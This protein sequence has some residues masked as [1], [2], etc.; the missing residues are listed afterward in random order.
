MFTRPP[1]TASPK[2]QAALISTASRR[3]VLGSAVNMTPADAAST[4]SWTTT[5]RL[6]LGR[7]DALT[8][9][10]GHRPRRPQ[11]GPAPAYGLQHRVGA[12]D[13]Q[14]GVLLAGEAGALEVLGGRR[15]ADRHGARPELRGRRRRCAAATSSGTRPAVNRSL[16]A[17]AADS[18][19]ADR[20]RRGR[21]QRDD[22][23]A[24]AG[25]CRRTSRYAAVVTTKPGGTGSPARPAHRGW[26]PCRRP[27][28]GRAGRRRPTRPPATDLTP[29]SACRSPRLP[30]RPNLRPGRASGD[31]AH[32]VSG[33]DQRYSS[34][35]FSRTDFGLAPLN[36]LTSSPP[37]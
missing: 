23:L 7:V 32:V 34:I 6:H 12:A 10:V 24:Q 36:A 17:S 3:P 13:V 18:Y 11:R 2:P 20:R 25:E 15:G 33:E 5:A 16:I 9:P 4:S 1:T 31:G 29:W 21:H 30:R 22:P 19:A 14:V 26:L 27:T 35:A 28:P 37:T 8:S